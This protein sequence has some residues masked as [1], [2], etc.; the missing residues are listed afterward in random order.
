[1]PTKDSK[2][3][4]LY[5]D[6]GKV[7]AQECVDANPTIEPMMAVSKK[8]TFIEVGKLNL[9]SVEGDDRLVSYLEDPVKCDEFLVSN[10]GKKRRVYAAI[11]T[12]FA[13]KPLFTAAV[14]TFEEKEKAKEERAVKNA[15]KKARKSL[16]TVTAENARLRDDFAEAEE[17]LDGLM[18][19]M[20]ASPVAEPLATSFL[21]SEASEDEESSSDSSDDEE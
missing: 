20:L 10:R 11:K 19:R 6:V 1:M 3:T 15:L 17:T 7:E 12:K 4:L 21:A 2:L 16:E 9:D 8:P 5:A 13:T 18:G 14:K